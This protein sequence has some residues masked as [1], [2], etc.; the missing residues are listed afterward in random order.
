MS[1]TTEVCESIADARTT[2]W[3][4][5][6]EAPHVSGNPTQP[7]SIKIC[8]TPGTNSNPMLLREKRSTH[9][10]STFIQLSPTRITLN[11][12]QSQADRGLKILIQ[13]MG[14][15]FSS[16]IDLVHKETDLPRHKNITAINR[17]YKKQN[18]AR[19][20]CL[21]CAKAECTFNPNVQTFEAATNFT[22][23]LRTTEVQFRNAQA[24]LEIGS[25]KPKFPTLFTN[26]F[27]NN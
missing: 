26:Y 11:V 7:K 12:S 10:Q 18:N 8:T 19:N 22:G 15:A 1:E 25:S 23:Y 3:S 5:P 20:R 16:S 21:G 4:W 27:S 2:A 24:K 13:T 14:Q 6:E 9:F 17:L